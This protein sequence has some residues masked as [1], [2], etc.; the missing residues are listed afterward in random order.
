[1]DK[2]LSYRGSSI[3]YKISGTGN[4]AVLIHGFG[5]DGSIWKRQAG[6][7]KDQFHLIIPDL[8]G[9]GTSGLISNISIEGMADMVNAILDNENIS[10]CTVIGHSMGG[11][12]TLA[13]AE[14]YS[15]VLNGFGL[16]HSTSYADSEEKK[17]NRRKSIE[18]I[19][20]H[21]S[22]EFLKNITPNLFS[23][24]SN[25]RFKKEINE[26]I[27]SLRYFT[28]EAL[29]AYYEA[30]IKRPDRSAQLTESPVPVL[31]VIGQYDTVIP[32][33]DL[34]QQSHL[35]SKAFIHILSESGH[36]GMMEESG[37]S[38]SVLE[39]FLNSL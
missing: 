12:I 30:M 7:L 27:T 34:L 28:P 38:N 20:Q 25:K 33:N 32:I 35:P 15:S 21:G 11:Y 1:M 14:K 29:I 4:T 6:Y 10:D 36:M 31:F 19:K 18:F 16:F 22:F 8:P 3:H 9:S 2:Y 26:F 13:F 37:K 23:P 39:N 24:D 17:A 5:E